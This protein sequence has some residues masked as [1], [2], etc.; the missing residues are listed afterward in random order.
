M[1]PDREDW[2]KGQVRQ[3]PAQVMRTSSIDAA[4][5][6]A[7]DNGVQGQ[8]KPCGFAPHSGRVLVLLKPNIT[9]VLLLPGIS[10]A[11]GLRH[12]NGP[13]ER[14]ESNWATQP[15]AFKK[16]APAL[17]CH[18]KYNCSRNEN[19]YYIAREPP[20][21]AAASHRQR[22]PVQGHRRCKEFGCINRSFTL[23]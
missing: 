9:P 18:I 23:Q 19:K 16:P 8:G 3:P 2:N 11:G 17:C 1:E 15:F 6:P 10:I 14:E 12:A 13:V 4:L 7:M 22:Q 21:R 5:A 20:F